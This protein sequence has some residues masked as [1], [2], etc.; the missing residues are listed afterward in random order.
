MRHYLIILLCSLMTQSFAQDK[1]AIKPQFYSV[2]TVEEVIGD[3]RLISYYYPLKG[4]IDNKTSIVYVSDTPK[5]EDVERAARN[6]PSDFF[7]V[8]RNK[9]VQNKVMLI[10]LPVRNFYVASPQTGQQEEFPCKLKGDI[11]ENRANE[12]IAE[13]YDTTAKIEGGKLHFNNKRFDIIT[14]QAIRQEVLDLIAAQHLSK[15]VVPTVK[16]TTKSE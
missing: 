12:I 16:K 7:Q 11:T 1:E 4:N 13:K 10:N 9:V 2:V 8:S 14:N 3:Y 6:L 15:P 5:L